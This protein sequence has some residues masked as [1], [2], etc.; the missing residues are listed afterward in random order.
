M[1]TVWMLF[2]IKPEITRTKDEMEAVCWGWCTNY[3]SPGLAT[4]WL[5][6]TQEK[7]T[8]FVKALMI[9]WVIAQGLSFPKTVQLDFRHLPSA[10]KDK[11]IIKKRGPFSCIQTVLLSSKTNRCSWS[12]WTHHEPITKDFVSRHTRAW[13]S[14]LL[15]SKV[16]DWGSQ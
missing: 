14:T 3:I 7:S 11:A 10:W 8:L 4:S 2:I 16:M 5:L 1:V 12:V 6:V 15:F 9:P 13:G